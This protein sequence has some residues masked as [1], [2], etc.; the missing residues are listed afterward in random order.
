MIIENLNCL[1]IIYSE[2]D[3]KITDKK[4]TFFTN[5]V[6]LG[7]D[8]S[9]S[10][11]EEVSYDVWRNY[12]TDFIPTNEGEKI[13]EEIEALKEENLLL[14]DLLLETDYRLLQIELFGLNPEF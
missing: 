7:K 1:T 5:I 13:K 9:I 10:N 8:D 6:Y 14:G 2:G 11:Y 12:L 4:R 3:N